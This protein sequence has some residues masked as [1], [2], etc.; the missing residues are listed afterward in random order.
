MASWKVSVSVLSMLA[1]CEPSAPSSGAASP[2]GG[3]IDVES[4]ADAAD[5]DVAVQDG[6][7][8]RLDTSS[9]EPCNGWP[10]LCERRYDR[11]TFPATH[12]SAAAGSP[13]KYPAQKRGVRAQL[14]DNIRAIALAIYDLDGDVVVCSEDCAEGHVVHTT[15][16]GDLRAFL[17]DNPRQVVTLFVENHVPAALVAGLLEEDGLST[18]LLTWHA[19]DPWPTLGQMIAS[20]RR[21]VVFA[22]DT[23]GAPDTLVPSSPWMFSTSADFH[24]PGEMNCDAR[25]GDPHSTFMLVQHFLT[26]PVDGSRPHGYPSEELAEE[27]NHNPLLIDRLTG[28]RAQYN[29]APSFVAV[30]FYDA[31][32][33]VAATQTL[34]GLG[35]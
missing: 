23:A 30:D 13:F 27:I 15:A 20:G 22:D 16:L 28:C 8:P 6:L 1:A 33:V 25:A 9:P 3:D 29:R 26:A 11:V 35:P 12:A 34:N 5:V 7:A 18:F 14:D 31:S 17:D 24:S 21:L 19:G 4:I 32:D 10:E 2:E